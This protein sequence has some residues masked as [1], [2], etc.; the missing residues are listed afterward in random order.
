V[1]HAYIQLLSI[2][3][4]VRQYRHVSILTYGRAATTVLLHYRIGVYQ[5]WCVIRVYGVSCWYSS[6]ITTLPRGERADGGRNAGNK[7]GR[8]PEGLR[9][10]CYSSV[11]TVLPSKTRSIS[12]RLLSR[13]M[14]AASISALNSRSVNACE[15][16]RAAA[17]L[18][19]AACSDLMS[20]S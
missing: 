4:L 10:V 18:Q 12:L 5:A 14:L 8:N 11:A 1:F 2:A 19:R 13:A 17:M 6:S 7:K 16:C 9:P 15:R 20:A 3:V